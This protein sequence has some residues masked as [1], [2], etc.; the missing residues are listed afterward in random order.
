V[1]SRSHHDDCGGKFISMT[2][3][4]LSW[5]AGL[6]V[7]C[8]RTPQP[9]GPRVITAVDQRSGT[10]ALLIAVSPVDERTVWVSGSAG[11]WLRTTDGGA[12]W[13]TGR[14]PGADSLQF[15][16]VHAVDA[17]TAYLLSI[18]DGPQSRIYKT[19][20]AGAHW[21]LQF[22]NPDPK[23]FYDCMAFWDA[24]RGVA[25]GDALGSEVAML[26]TSDGGA[27]WTRI[28]PSSLPPAMP[29]EGSFA[30]SGTC[31]VTR[32]GGHA[33]AVASNPS[34]GRVLH[35][36][37]YGRTWR[38]DTLPITT[39]EGSGPQS[40]AFRDDRHGVALGGG[41]NARAGDVLAALTS[42][43]GHTWIARTRPPLKSGVWGGVFVPG[44][45]RPSVVAVGPS[46]AVWSGDDGASWMTIDT[47][48]YWSV[49]FASA[50]AGWAVGTR[51]RITKLSGF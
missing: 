36:T 40:I 45:E 3:L 17:N 48:N 23:G 47:L 28:P 51:G 38:V 46:G 13:Q 16:D 2:S 27:H 21:T 31:L 42:D 26:T 25:I 10:T 19:T 20:D 30:A 35:S 32:P 49:G 39:R 44:A 6:A 14:V 5:I 15:R 7:A 9:A 43:G 8:S 11:T 18:G 12:T 4:R 22:T 24:K 37:D 50:R 29:N 1:Y 41:N 33:W 34:H